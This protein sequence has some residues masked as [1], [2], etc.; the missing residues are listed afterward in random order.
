MSV[1]CGQ[2]DA[3]P[4]VTY[5][6]ARHHRP[7]CVNNLPRVALDSWENIKYC[8]I[9]SHDTMH[10]YSYSALAVAGPGW[11]PERVPSCSSSPSVDLTILVPWTH[12]TARH[13][14]HARCN[15]N[16]ET[17]KI[18]NQNLPTAVRTLQVEMSAFST[19]PWRHCYNAALPPVMDKILEYERTNNMLLNTY[20]SVWVCFFSHSI[21]ISSSVISCA[22]ANENGS[23]LTRSIPR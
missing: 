21:L 19:A 2:C 13:K 3:R 8:I 4:T 11:W 1:T 18:P 5:P 7:L 17:I 9:T 10:L 22:T 20:C 12:F 14:T 6:A 15:T 23:S 16:V